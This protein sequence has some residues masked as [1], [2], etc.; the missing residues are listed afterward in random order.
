MENA[1]FAQPQ[2]LV[3]SII[4]SNA[5]VPTDIP[6]A[7][8]KSPFPSKILVQ[9][10]TAPQYLTT[11]PECHV[12]IVDELT[13]LTLLEKIIPNTASLVYTNTDLGPVTVGA[14]KRYKLQMWRIGGS[15]GIV[16]IIVRHIHWIHI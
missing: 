12:A 10:E 4:L 14:M 5:A 1:H 3:N 8:I 9:F 11:A 7:I 2:L 6:N 13:G 15:G 16:R